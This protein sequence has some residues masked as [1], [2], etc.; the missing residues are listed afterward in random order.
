MKSTTSL[1]NHD[2]QSLI[3]KTCDGHAKHSSPSVF[4]LCD[5]YYW[6]ATYLNKTRIRMDSNCLQ[7]NAMQRAIN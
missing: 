3:S 5:R 6:C 2:S 4:I 1:N 7:C